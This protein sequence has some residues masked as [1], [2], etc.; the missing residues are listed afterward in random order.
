MIVIK[1]SKLQREKKALIFDLNGVLVET[2][3]MRAI[4]FLGRRNVGAYL[5]VDGK[6]PSSLKNLLYSVLHNE[7]STK[8]VVLCDPYGDKLPLIFEHVFKG[9][10]PES[11]LYSE[12]YNY[13]HNHKDNF[14]NER[15]YE[16]CCKVVEILFNPVQL[17]SLQQAKTNTLKVLTEC[18][19]LGHELFIASN[20]GKESFDLLYKALP[21]VF[22][23]VPWEHIFISAYVDAM[24]PEAHMYNLLHAKIQEKGIISSALNTYFVDDQLENIQGAIANNMQGIHFTGSTVLRKMLKEYTVL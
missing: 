20:Y 17:I 9:T 14:I 5:L 16:L 22:E 3:L 13:V 7:S 23:S 8:D 1:S 10:Y 2:S 4:K 15:E 6:T 18:K 24:K 11:A 21:E 12:A 19:K